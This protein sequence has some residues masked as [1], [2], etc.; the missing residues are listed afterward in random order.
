[1]KDRKCVALIDYNI[2]VYTN[3]SIEYLS[4]KKDSIFYYNFHSN[5]TSVEYPIEYWIKIEDEYKPVS[6][7][8]FEM[9]FADLAKIRE[10]RIN[11]ILND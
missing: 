6:V 4:V 3:G 2:T 7:S 8:S 9:V 1:M 11:K 10:R 5:G